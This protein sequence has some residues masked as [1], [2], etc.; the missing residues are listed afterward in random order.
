MSISK[1]ILNGVTQID[2]TDTTATAADV[3]LGK[4]FY[5]AAGIKTEG[6]GSGGGSGFGTDYEQG[7]F[8]PSQDIARPT[9]SFARTHTSA[10]T[11]VMIIDS[12]NSTAVTNSSNI[13]FVFFDAY[14]LYGTTVYAY[15]NTRYA[16]VYYSYLT[17]NGV[18]YGGY[19]LIY[20]YEDPGDSTAD[21]TRYY[22]TESAFYPNS[23]STSRY[24]R[25]G[26]TYK[27]IAIWT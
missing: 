20:S 12:G 13:G 2:V 1:F 10:P 21:Y 16:H 17:S 4:F 3:A 26:R 14:K 22:A 8:V 5:D 23:R 6:T 19:T 11:I 18:Q 27:W 24:W 9:I 25:N 15:N 7:I